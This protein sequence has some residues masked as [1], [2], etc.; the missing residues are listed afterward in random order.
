MWSTLQFVNTVPNHVL[1]Y[2]EFSGCLTNC[3]ILA[4]IIKKHGG[5][6]YFAFLCLSLSLSLSLS[7]QVIYVIYGYSA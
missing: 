4:K 5:V 3:K 6:S 2:V 1:N 7:L